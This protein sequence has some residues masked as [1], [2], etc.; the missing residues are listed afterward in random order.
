VAE[1]QLPHVSP[2]V[3]QLPEAT[4]Q[5]PIVHW[6]VQ[7]CALEVQAP[8]VWVHWPAAEQVSVIG[9]Q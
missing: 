1:Q 2:R 7:H 8:P 9:S 6:F 5:V 4:W 3:E